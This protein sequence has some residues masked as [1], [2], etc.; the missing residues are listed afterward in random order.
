MSIVAALLAAAG[1]V[2]L[3][4]LLAD[5]QSQARE[6]IRQRFHERAEVSA[7]MTEAVFAIS[8][9]TNMQLAQ[10]RLGGRKVDGD[11]LEAVVSRSRLLYARL[12]GS[13]GELLAITRRSPPPQEP[14]PE[15]VRK[16]LAGRATLADV[17]TVPGSGERVVEWAIPYETRF[18]RRVQVSG[19]R[20]TL[21]AE[22]LGG[23][24]R[25][26][27]RGEGGESYVIDG[28]DQVV[29]SLDPK[30][31]DAAPLADRELVAAVRRGSSGEYE[32][33][34]ADR[35][36]TS[37][38]VDDSPWHVVLAVDQ[39]D[40][41]DEV[42]GART[43]VPWVIFAALLLAAIAGVLLLRRIAVARAAVERAA[44]DQRHAV[45][46]N[47]NI[48]QRISLAKYAMDRGEAGLT[49][50]KLAETLEE[51]QR[52]VNELLGEGD[53]EPGRLRRGTDA[54]GGGAS[55]G[56]DKP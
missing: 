40:L 13:K 2:V 48:I 16:A 5:A 41:Y 8:A 6:D 49:K 33:D 27:P 35:Y 12:R 4:L 18:G 53:I 14:P 20:E 32:R 46:I 3:A 42:S 38:T 7:A 45:E 37:E 28:K 26:L 31:V 24:L 56:G 43:L 47:D 21:I 55:G 22:F 30:A 54:P 9:Q 10:T 51:A 11:Q 50:E 44:A 39:S 17:S 1:L 23:L 36:F 25:R 15:F 34:G 52:L 19:L 29:A